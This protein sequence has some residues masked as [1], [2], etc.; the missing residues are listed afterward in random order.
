MKFKELSDFVFILK[1]RIP[2]DANVVLD[3]RNVQRFINEDLAQEVCDFDYDKV[4]NEFKVIFKEAYDKK[5]E[6]LFSKRFNLSN[7]GGN[8]YG[9]Y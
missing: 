9:K 3:F 7:V 6:V 1:N 4:T 8:Y 2:E 5:K